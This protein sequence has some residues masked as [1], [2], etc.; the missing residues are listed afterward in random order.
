MQEARFLSEVSNLRDY[1]VKTANVSPAK[2]LLKQLTGR[3]PVAIIMALRLLHGQGFIEWEPETLWL[4]LEH[5]GISTTAED[6]HK[7]QAA[8]TLLKNPAFFWDSIVFQRTVQAFDEEVTDPDSL[9][10][11]HAAVMSW[12]I[13]SAI[14]VRRLDEEDNVVPEFDE[15]V[16]AFVAVCLRRQGFVLAPEYL[17]FSQEVLDKQWAKKDA[18]FTKEVKD[19]FE[20]LDKSA[21]AHTEFAE[22]PL[23]VQLAQLSGCHLYLAEKIS[24][25]YDD[26]G[27]LKSAPL[28]T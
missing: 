11:P 12:A 22:D 5:D 16:Q 19:A 13:Y 21:L 1:L 9:V 23:G 18:S 8:I 2:E 26:I 6:R 17:D 27:L 25:M 15:D 4:T 3:S 10:E 14:A 20:H 28:V 24:S 7:I